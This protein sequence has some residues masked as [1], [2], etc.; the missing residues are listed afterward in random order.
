MLRHKSYACLYY[1]KIACLIYLLL[2][3]LFC[4]IFLFLSYFL[5]LLKN[6]V[7]LYLYFCLQNVKLFKN[8]KLII[9]F[10]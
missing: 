4:I 7:I 1:L 10:K 8:F 6:I 9:I 2:I 3:L 5:E